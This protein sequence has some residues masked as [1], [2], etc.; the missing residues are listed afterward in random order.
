MLN[1][2]ISGYV[3][4]SEHCCTN[5]MKMECSSHILLST[6]RFVK[7]GANP[8][9]CNYVVHKWSAYLLLVRLI[10]IMNMTVGVF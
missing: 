4:T 10:I 5:Y 7:C 9:K 3:R 8:M 1:S 6:F 2:V